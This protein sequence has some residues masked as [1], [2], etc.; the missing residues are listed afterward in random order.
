MKLITTILLVFSVAVSSCSTYDQDNDVIRQKKRP[1]Q[2]FIYTNPN[3]VAIDLKNISF[4]TNGMVRTENPDVLGIGGSMYS[5]TRFGA[6]N[7]R[8]GQRDVFA[9]GDTPSQPMNLHDDQIYY[10][11]ALRSVNQS[12]YD[13]RLTYSLNFNENSFEGFSVSIPDRYTFGNSIL[14]HG[15]MK[16]DTIVGTVESGN[17][18]G[19]FSGQFYGPNG[20]EF[21]GIARFSNPN[22]DFSFGGDKQ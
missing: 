13:N 18:K 7:S 10:G 14:M 5:Y 22:L 17:D 1:P 15:Q 9:L 8:T 12:V 2:D 3:G 20:I 21:V 6:W 4:K 19:T 16:G 11:R